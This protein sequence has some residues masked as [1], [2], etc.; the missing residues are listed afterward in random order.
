[1]CAQSYAEVPL[2]HFQLF[3]LHSIVLIFCCSG[4]RPW[5]TSVRIQ[6]T[7]RSTI[8]R[9]R[10]ERAAKDANRT[11]NVLAC[12]LFMKDS[13]SVTRLGYFRKVS[14]TIF[15]T[16]IAQT[17]EWLWGLFWMIIPNFLAPIF[18]FPFKCLKILK[19]TMWLCV[20]LFATWNA[21]NISS[22]KFDFYSSSFVFQVL[23]NLSL[24]I[25]Y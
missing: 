2:K 11:S 3:L 20:G 24:Q 17:S 9:I 15:V 1:M 19:F 22:L 18:H 13:F 16:I 25:R 6:S 5:W 4:C 12:S 10:R 23:R 7:I 14:V 21:T 8:F